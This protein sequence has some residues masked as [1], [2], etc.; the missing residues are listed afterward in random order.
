MGGLIKL[1]IAAHKQSYVPNHPLLVPLQIGTALHQPLPGMLYDN[2]GVN[3]S[4]QNNTYCELTG[5]Y[6]VWKN[7]QA[8]YYGFYHYRRYFTFAP[9]KR[10]YVIYDYPNEATLQRM[11]YAPDKMVAFIQQYDLLVPKA[12]AMYETV[13]DN[14]RR[15]PYHFS[16][17]LQMM[18]QIVERRYPEYQSA[19][20]Q[21]LNGTQMYLKN[22]YIMKH[23]L[24][25]QYC[26]WLFPLL[27]EFDQRNDWSKY[28]NHPT[29]VRVDGYLAERLFGIWYTRLKQQGTARSGELSRVH[30]ADMD[31]GKGNLQKMKLVN[32]ILPSGTKRRSI[33]SRGARA[34][35][36]KKADAKLRHS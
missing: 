33:V 7:E 8:D 36:K 21:Y 20:M 23:D 15:A 10:P 6:W 4:A 31:G 9:Q 24:F 22:M 26:S 28:K 13:W 16:E 17:D 1:Y 3:L 14:Y 11:G 29:A 30:F 34:V 18:A 12:E 32:T 35:L 27:A 25:H 19:V 5:Q 2:D